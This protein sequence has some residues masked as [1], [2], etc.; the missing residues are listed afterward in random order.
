MAA[1]VYVAV[2][3]GGR[4]RKGVLE[5]DTARH[6]RQLLREQALLPVSVTEVVGEQKQAAADGAA[7][8]AGSRSSFSA[9]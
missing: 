7:P 1:F 4:E 8:A 9:G 2:D 3:A 6:V 5:G